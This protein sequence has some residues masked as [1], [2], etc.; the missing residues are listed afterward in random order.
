MSIVPAVV[1]LDEVVAALLEWRKGSRPAA[2]RMAKFLL[3]LSP[4]QPFTIRL[5]AA[6]EAP[7]SEIDFTC[8]VGDRNIAEGRLS[9]TAG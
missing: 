8:R 4:E 7:E 2:I 9:C 5:S 3:P 1:I 6:R